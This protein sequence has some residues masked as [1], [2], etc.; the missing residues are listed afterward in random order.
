MMAFSSG[1]GVFTM[2]RGWHWGMY[3]PK[4]GLGNGLTPLIRQRAPW[5][6]EECRHLVT[7]T[8]CQLPQTQCL[9]LPQSPL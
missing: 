1:F 5:T 2:S 9:P 4:P 6:Q 8:S 7:A 3:W